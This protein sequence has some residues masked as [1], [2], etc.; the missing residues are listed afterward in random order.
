MS[1]G[2]I[3]TVTAAVPELSGQTRTTVL[4]G[5]QLVAATPAAALAGAAVVGSAVIAYAVEEAGDN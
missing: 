1:S 3:H 4:D 5:S 2:F